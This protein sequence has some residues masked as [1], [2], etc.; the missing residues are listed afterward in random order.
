M[1]YSRTTR[2][3]ARVQPQLNA[4]IEA[5]TSIEWPSDE[6]QKLAFKLREA[7]AAAKTLAMKDQETF[8]PY[9]ALAARYTIRC[10]AGK[11][12]A[13]PRELFGVLAVEAMRS[14]MQIET[15]VSL[16]EVLGA[17]IQHR[18]DEMVFPNAENWNEEDLIRL[19]KWTVQNSYFMIVGDGITLT[20]NDP[21]EAKWES[22]LLPQQND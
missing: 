5:K 10:K 6:P 16:L 2:S 4:M 7:I 17:A 18:A 11:V 19:H 15:A 20:K 12:V 8:G 13:E 3:I 22:K 1:A 21:G 14:K 9:A